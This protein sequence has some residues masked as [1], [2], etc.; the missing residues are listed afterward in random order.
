MKLTTSST[1][2][3]LALKSG[4]Y[5]LVS[6]RDFY[7]EATTTAGI[8]MHRDVVLRYIELQ[9][10]MMAV[11]APHWSEHI[12][13]EILKKV[14]TY[15]TTPLHLTPTNTLSSPRPSTTPAS[16]RSPSPPSSCPQPLT[17]PARPPPASPPRRPTS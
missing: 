11:I 2:F 5:D 15:P 3:K 7:R 6:A 1:N 16:P 9:A 17:T 4:L 8:G 10:L 12:W 13:L 14:R